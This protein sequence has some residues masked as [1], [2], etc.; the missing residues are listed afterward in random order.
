MCPH[1]EGMLEAQG[2]EECVCVCVCMCQNGMAPHELLERCCWTIG[3][4][5]Q[6]KTKWGKT[7]MRLVALHGYLGDLW[8]PVHSAAH[9]FLYSKASIDSL[10][11]L[12]FVIRKRV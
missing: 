6:D 8:L 7:I 12:S 9:G 1:S 4:T 5:R 11:Y 2:G 3:K 10:D